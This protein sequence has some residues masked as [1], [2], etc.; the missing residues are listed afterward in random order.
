MQDVFLRLLT[1]TFTTRPQGFF[2]DAAP[3]SPSSK[4][5][6]RTP[7]RSPNLLS[8][9]TTIAP[10]LPLIL[11]DNERVSTASSSISVH[12]VA[13]TIRSKSFP[14]NTSP[15]FLT[16]LLRLTKLPQASKFWR[17]DVTDALNDPRFF[18]TPI[19]VVKDY[20]FPVLAQLV[21]ADKDRMP[22]LLSRI[23]A[24]TTAG[25]VFGV[26]ATSARLDAD[27]K[28][29][30]NLRRIALLILAASTDTFA[31]SI[32][33][34]SETIVA[35]FTATPVSAPSSSIWPDLFILLRTLVLKTSSVHIAP[36]W[37]VIN[38]ELQ[39]A[40]LSILPNDADAP[41]G[42]KYNNA[43]LLQAAK[44]LDT[45]VTIEPDDFQIYEWLFVSDTI[46]TV[47]KPGDWA[48]TALVD[49]VAEAL[50]SASAST[51]LT[52][53]Q[54]HAGSI[55]T[56]SSSSSNVATR[57][58]MLD[59]LLD[60]LGDQ[61]DSRSMSKA[62]LAARVLRPYFGQLSLMA[63]EATYAG[64]AVDFEAIN[65]GLV[66]DLFDGSVGDIEG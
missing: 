22:D 28:T 30:L 56:A 33:P 43:T 62:E 5:T 61:S 49:E 36:L 18:L 31:P 9:L 58:P 12:V 14:T 34:L 1:A 57:K 51:P 54:P 15:T 53:H 64:H 39:S 27:R 40:I 13:P 20:W 25:V 11:V 41:G 37:P 42:D 45:L 2:Q 29:Q 52:P 10:K 59:L 17:K 19:D 60:S 23:S 8:I 32:G 21:T 63:F 3:S 44:L 48:P 65:I 6:S 4:G 7:V 24:P 38:R 47:Y 50:G 55:T 35:L 16:L 26:G 66:K 46:D